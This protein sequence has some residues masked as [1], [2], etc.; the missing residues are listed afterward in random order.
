MSKFSFDTVKDFDHHISGSIYGYSVLHS[1]IINISSF[2]IKSGVTPIDLGCTSGKLLKAVHEAY[3]CPV[4]GYDITPAQ[5]IDGLDLRVQ[6]ITDPDFVI[7]ETN[8]IYSVFTL[9]FID[10][11]KRIEVLRKV[12]RSLYKNGA[13]IFCEKEICANGIIQEVFTFS[14]YQY[15]RNVFT[16]E[17]ILAKEYDL[18]AMMNS[19]ESK[20]NIDLLK[21]AGFTTIEPFFK[22]L[23]FKGYLCKK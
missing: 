1:L 6:D 20:D 12:Y 8:L 15:K 21:E 4:I 9:Q 18:R 13:F 17:E 5:F 22:Y 16:P 10:Y 3:N 23:N 7:P 14:N 19:L 11:A 2:F